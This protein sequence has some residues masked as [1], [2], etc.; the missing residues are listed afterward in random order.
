MYETCLAQVQEELQLNAESVCLTSD[1][2]TSSVNDAY[3]GL[4]A[5]YIDNNFN[6]KSAGA[7]TA[8]NIKETVMRILEQFKLTEKVLI[9]VSDNASN[10]KSA[11]ERMGFRHFGCYAHTI[12]LIVKYCTTEHTADEMV[13]NLIIKVKS[14]V[15]YYKKSAKATE[16]LTI[17]GCIYSME[18]YLK[19]ARSIRPFR[20]CH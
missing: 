19:N 8:E 9:I 20:K 6:M 16:K 13:K 12:N 2:W 1:I 18:F 14:I 3:L 7:H 10:M 17:A 11:V 4:T 5:H 15:S